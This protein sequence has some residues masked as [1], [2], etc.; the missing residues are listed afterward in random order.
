[1]HAS[2]QVKA[3]LEI[4]RARYSGLSPRHP[5]FPRVSRAVSPA[6]NFGVPR[7]TP[8]RSR[9]SQASRTDLYEPAFI[10]EHEHAHA[11][12]LTRLMRLT[13]ERVRICQK[14]SQCSPHR[15]TRLRRVS[16]GRTRKFGRIMLWSRCRRC[17]HP[18]RQL[19]ETAWVGFPTFYVDERSPPHPLD[20]SHLVT[21][22]CSST[23]PAFPL[24]ALVPTHP[25]CQQGAV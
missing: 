7:A 8:S 6:A 14:M 5:A 18:E 21:T 25:V 23:R 12:T 4:H 20:M 1:M 9:D 24:V 11:S 13:R 17:R 19:R 3:L 2:R 22:L 16:R 15:K 10:C